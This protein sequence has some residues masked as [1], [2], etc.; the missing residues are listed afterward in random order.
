MLKH[1]SVS[2]GTRRHWA[3]VTLFFLALSIVQTWPLVLHMDDH[4]M[5]WAPD[6]YQHMWNLWWFKHQLLSLHNPFRTD[7]L[8]YPQGSDLY[9]HTLTPV[10]GLFTLPWQILS[11]NVILSW[12]IT[13]LLFLTAS[14]VGAYALAYRVSRDPWASLAGGMIFAFSP[15]VM[16]HIN[17]HLNISTTW[18]I[19]FFVLAVLSFHDTLRLRDAAIAGL[20]LSV[21][22]W[23]WLEF[24]IDSALF[25]VLFGGFWGAICFRRGDR[26]NALA[27][28]KGAVVL[29]AVWAVLSLPIMIPSVYEVASGDIQM[30]GG[31]SAPAEFY[32]ADLAGYVTPSPLWG[33]GKFANCDCGQFPVVIGGVEGTVFMGILPLLLS[34]VAPLGYWKS[35]K[36]LIVGFWGIVFAF[37]AVMALG[38]FLYVHGDKSFDLGFGSFSIPLPFRVFKEL[39]LI[40]LRRVPARMVVYAT[41][42]LAVLAPMGITVL[43]RLAGQRYVYAGQAIAVLAAAL[44]LL[45]FWNP[46]VSLSSYH[47]P[48]IYEQIGDEDGDFTL[49]E[50]PVGRITGT[51]QRGDINGGGMTDYSQIIHGKASI[52]GYIS[53]GKAKDVLWLR[54]QP[55]IG[56]LSC[57]ICPGFPRPEDLDRQ[58]VLGEFDELNIKYV[59]VNLKTFEGTPTAIVT[60]DKQDVFRD[61][62]EETLGLERVDEGDGWIA[63]RNPG[64]N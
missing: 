61:Y 1:V 33:P 14:G 3:L 5:A 51:E 35:D 4:V 43:K 29:S 34:A 57:P 59:I 40:G 45:E 58:R 20:L 52:G 23:N 12:G 60:D 62:L 8:F 48:S 22:T 24:T 37:F 31:L 21:M 2:V 13:S 26:E 30:K 7:L 56:F 47:V 36:R 32:S 16:T 64:V 17:G 25:L 6:G 55:G 46:P 11:G 49:L 41:L 28:L 18:P 9:M 39:P 44:V 50:L 10:N 27:L 19:P 53:R 42:S 15:F 54:E 63:Y 38:P